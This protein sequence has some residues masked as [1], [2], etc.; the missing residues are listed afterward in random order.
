MAGKVGGGGGQSKLATAAAACGM[1]WPGGGGSGRG[2]GRGGSG[3]VA[4]DRH[5]RSW[6]SKTVPRHAGAARWQRHSHANSR[7]DS[8][9]RFSLISVSVMDMATPRLR[10]PPGSATLGRAAVFCARKGCD[11]I[12]PFVLVAQSR[13]APIRARLRLML[14][15][16]QGSRVVV[17]RGGRA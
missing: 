7:T 2:G 13:V 5:R 9:T 8:G 11:G 10:M 15:G 14:R 6:R 16:R 4:D 1:R 12:R 3:R 17:G